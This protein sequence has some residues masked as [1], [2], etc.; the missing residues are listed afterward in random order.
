MDKIGTMTL[1]ASHGR[2]K[3]YRVEGRVVT[4]VVT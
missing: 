3:R 4:C 1:G 2:S